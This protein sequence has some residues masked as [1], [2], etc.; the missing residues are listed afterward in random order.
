MKR[1]FLVLVLMAVM[2]AGAFA[3]MT[4]GGGGYFASDFGGGAKGKYS[5]VDASFKMPYYGGGIYAFFDPIPYVEL[6]VGFFFAAGS[7]D[8]SASAGGYG[9]SSS[10]EM[11]YNGLDIGVFGKYPVNIGPL[12]VFP[13][14]GATFRSFTTVD[15]KGTKYDGSK[16]SAFWFKAGGGLDFSITEKLFLRANLLYGIR[17]KNKLEEELMKSLNWSNG[18]LQL[19]HG[20]EVKVAVGYKL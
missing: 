19:G 4:V 11:N 16:A 13:L 8:V 9:A 7:Y 14:I 18:D 17:L 1:G 2:A 12:T 20:L 3:Q 10:T 15:M 5:G 6:N